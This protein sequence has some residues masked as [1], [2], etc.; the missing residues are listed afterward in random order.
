[1]TTTTS[2][3]PQAGEK[4][5][6]LTFNGLQYA[7]SKGPSPLPETEVIRI[8]NNALVLNAVVVLIGR[9]GTGKTYLMERTTPNKIVDGFCE[10]SRP[11]FDLSAVPEGLFSIDEAASFDCNS[12]RDGIGQLDKRGFIISMQSASDLDELGIREVLSDR[13]VLVAELH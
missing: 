6:N 8:L 9:A 1:M 4:Q 5:F 3:S 2:P 7:E 13:R 12:L 10:V 11:A